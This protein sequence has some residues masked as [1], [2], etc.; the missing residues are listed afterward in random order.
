MA[1]HDPLSSDPSANAVREVELAIQGMSCAACA[2]R[3]EKVLNRL[4]QT[5]AQVSFA[6]ERALLRTTQPDVEPMLAAVRKAGFEATEVDP[7]AWLREDAQRVAR[8]RHDVRM[9]WVAV[10]LTAPFVVQMLMMIAGH[11][12]AMAH[13]ALPAWLQFALATPVQ[14]WLGGRFYRGA[15]SALRGGGAN[16]DVLVALGTSVAWA[17]STV[18]WLTG[19]DGAHLYFEASAMI[20]T[21][22]LLG[23]WLEARARVQTSAALDALLRLQPARARVERDGTV[24]EVAADAV[25]PGDVF[26]VRA[27]DAVPVDGKII[28]GAS[29]LDEAALTGESAPRRRERGDPVYAATHNLDGLLRC[30]A[31]GVGQATVLAS[32]IRTVARVQDSRADI[33]RLADRVSAVFV[34]AVLMVALVTFAAWW[35]A[36]GDG[37]TALINAV[38]VLVIAC[39]CALGLA[40]PTAVMVGSG[41]GARAGLLVKNARVL[42]VAETLDVLALDKTGTLTE[43]RPRVEAV[44]P[45]SEAEADDVLALAAALERHSTHPLA[46]AIVEAATARGL[47]ADLPMQDVRVVGGG[48]IEAHLDERFIV[49]GTRE[50]LQQCGVAV[51]EDPGALLAEKGMSLAYVARDARLLGVIGMRDRLRPDAEA[52]VSHL[53]AAGVVPVI[54]S[55]DQPAAVRSVAAQLGIDAVHAGL[56]PAQKADEIDRLQAQGR[57]VGMVGDGINDAPA[58]AAANVSFAMGS[59]TEVAVKA[60]DVTLMQG[61]LWGVIDTLSLSR[62]TLRKI[63]Q[64]LF[65]AFFYNLLGIPAAALGLLSPTIAGAAMAMSSVSVVSNALLLRRWRPASRRGQE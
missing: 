65:F 24:V 60:A 57:V 45:V 37:V 11:E 18:V 23:K 22:V 54:L 20:V 40:T 4:P 3:L 8:L 55:G 16:M 14:F 2:V 15:W 10:A 53:K 31:T 38:S 29:S 35:G 49:I 63:R 42:E 12:A 39:P 61:S 51:T 33:Q 28:E 17:F 48:G 36:S 7:H 41:L 27:G 64:N 26:V 46:H 13:A 62:A 32:I 47:L 25:S 43:G 50:Y 9:L 59:G 34:P 56:L 19:F 5:R 44:M 21:L 1:H 52:M 58:L 6:T 30:R